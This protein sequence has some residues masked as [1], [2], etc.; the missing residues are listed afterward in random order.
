MIATLVN[1]L[2]TQSPQQRRRAFSFVPSFLHYKSARFLNSMSSSRVSA[3]FL[4]FLA[5]REAHF[6]SF[7]SNINDSSPSHSSSTATTVLRTAEEGSSSNHLHR[8]S[9]LGVAQRQQVGESSNFVSPTTVL[10]ADEAL[11]EKS[12]KG[13]RPTTTVEA[14]ENQEND[15]VCSICLE[16]FVGIDAKKKPFPCKVNEF[17]FH[18]CFG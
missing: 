16:A 4:A 5:S 12:E 9:P 13:K 15:C 17:N 6:N 10:D 11:A 2:L 8:P 14:G 1:V 7:S 3:E 18:T